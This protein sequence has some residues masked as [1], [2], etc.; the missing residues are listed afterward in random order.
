MD[1]D[2]RKQKTIVK[3]FFPECITSGTGVKLVLRFM[4]VTDVGY[5]WRQALEI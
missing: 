5:Y 2:L 1:N 4:S 3:T